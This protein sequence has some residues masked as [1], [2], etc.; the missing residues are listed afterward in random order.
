MPSLT[1]RALAELMALP[2]YE[3]YRVLYDQKYPKR[4][5]G[6]FRAPYYA[7]AL[8]GIRAYYASGNSLSEIETARQALSSA[9]NAVRRSHNER[10][11]ASFVDSPQ[12]T[13]SLSPIRNQRVTLSLSDTDLRA[14]FDLVVSDGSTTRRIF[15]NMRAVPLDEELARTT[16]EV[17][18]WLLQS[19]D[20]RTAI[21]CLE[22]VDL[23][24]NGVSHS[25]KRAR[26]TTVR[27][28]EQTL[29]VVE[30]LWPTI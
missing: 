22:Y 4:Q 12:S 16:L 23:A 25:F 2:G 14:T 8:R 21:D 17:V 1:V 28:A 6:V 3:Q 13:R 26:A 11:L 7:P 5:P 20:V 30:A 29:K 10:V 19:S 9:G 27:R 24:N 18:H 15:Y